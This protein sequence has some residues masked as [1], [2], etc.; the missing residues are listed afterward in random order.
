[1]LSKLFTEFSWGFFSTASNHKFCDLQAFFTAEGL[2][3]IPP[4]RDTCTK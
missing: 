3:Q 1:M 4:Y 2:F